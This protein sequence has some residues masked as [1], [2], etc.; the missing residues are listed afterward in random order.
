[1]ASFAAEKICGVALA[2]GIR[3]AF[4]LVSA[5]VIEAR[6]RCGRAGDRYEAVAQGCV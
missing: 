2:P 3:A 6:A 1:M 5:G 4:T